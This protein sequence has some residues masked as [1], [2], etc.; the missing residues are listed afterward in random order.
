MS[1]TGQWL[2]VTAIVLLAAVFLGR[3]I[4]KRLTA[5]ESR[6]GCGSCSHH[7]ANAQQ[8]VVSLDSLTSSAEQASR[9]SAQR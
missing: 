7:P 5:A 9:K 3:R 1:S 4:W 6:P 8:N 2:I